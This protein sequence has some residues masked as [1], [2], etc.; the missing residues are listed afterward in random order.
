VWG[1]WVLAS[2]GAAAELWLQ[3][4]YSAGEGLGKLGSW[5]LL[6]GTLHT[7]YG[8]FHS[9]RLLLL[10]GLALW[11]GWALRAEART[12]V[13]HAVWPLLIGVALTFAEV[14]H[15]ATTKPTWLS[16]TSDTAHVGA[17]TFW[18]GGLALLLF[19]ALPSA[20]E[21]DVAAALPVFSRVAMVAVGTIAVTGG[22]AAWRGVGT[23]HAVFST[24]Y[25]LLVSLKVLLF[26][27]LLAVG[28]QSRKAVARFGSGGRE[29][30]R[31]ALVVEVVIAVS[32]LAATGVLVAE[33]RGKEAL[34]ASHQKARSASAALSATREV[35]V[36]VDPGTHG[37]VSI[38]VALSAGD[39]PLS[40]TG[41]ASLPSREI[42]PIPLGLTAN[43]ENLYGASGVNLPGAGNWTFALV[44]QT[45]T[46]VATTVDV[47]VRLY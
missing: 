8:Q 46:F 3:G 45:S 36:T 35:T 13:D 34:A 25:G 27:A 4:P 32:V 40:V 17:M 11:L 33:P 37:V 9:V 7:D 22:Y 10:A 18:L 16:I 28:N 19:A 14:G 15:A 39:K 43:G 20:D 42:G 38:A 21:G 24:S 44:V 30:L 41:T 26:I 5:A 47:T 23:I 1:G 31:R 12:V 6:D 2:A 29:K